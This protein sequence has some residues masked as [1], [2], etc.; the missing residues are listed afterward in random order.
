VRATNS[1]SPDCCWISTLAQRGYVTNASIY[2]FVPQ[3]SARQPERRTVPNLIS[4]ERDHPVLYNKANSQSLLK[5]RVLHIHVHPR[6]SLAALLPSNLTCPAEPPLGC[7]SNHLDPFLCLAKVYSRL[8][9]IPRRK[10]RV[11]QLV[12]DLERVCASPFGSVSKPP[13]LTQSMIE[14]AF[15]WAAPVPHVTCV[16]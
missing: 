14:E 4:K 13:D 15:E 16:Q 11:A 8:C 7:I 2:T 6:I 1:I 10:Q 9:P 5:S 12:L 3:I